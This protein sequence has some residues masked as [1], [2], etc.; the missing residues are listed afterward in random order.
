MFYKIGK[1][2]NSLQYHVNK[3]INETLYQ[4]K[5]FLSSKWSFLQHNVLRWSQRHSHY[6]FLS[7]ILAILTVTNLVL[8]KGELTPIA[9][10][11]FPHWK[12]LTEWQGVFL[13]G[14]LTIVGVLYPLVIG[15]IGV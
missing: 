3:N 8:W 15:L 2:L 13:A 9:I 1:L 14:Q 4:N 6:I 5:A 12:K 10:S 7:V 11:Y